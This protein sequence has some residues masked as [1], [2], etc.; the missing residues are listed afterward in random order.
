MDNIS[1]Y[2]MLQNCLLAYLCV[3]ILNQPILYGN[4]QNY[5]NIY[6]DDHKDNTNSLEFKLGKPSAEIKKTSWFKKLYNKIYKF[7]K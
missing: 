5:K 7:K 1:I 6:D 2:I 4:N 3:K